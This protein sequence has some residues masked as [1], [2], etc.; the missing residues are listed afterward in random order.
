MALPDQYSGAVRKT[1]YLAELQ[2][3]VTSHQRRVAQLREEIR[4]AEEEISFHEV[5]LDLAHNRQLI[6]TVVNLSDDSGFK[7]AFATDPH[8]YCREADIA[9]PEGVTLRPLDTEHPSPRL[10]AH[11]RRGAWD[12]EIVWERDVGFFVRPYLGPT[13]IGDA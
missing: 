10:T 3:D 7:S 13:A 8:Q 5:V 12:M 9:L 1:K 6:E 4:R 11:V 2:N